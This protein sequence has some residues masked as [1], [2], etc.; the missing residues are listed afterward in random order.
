M[1]KKH[2][3]HQLTFKSTEKSLALKSSW[4]VRTLFLVMSFYNRI[5]LNH[6]FYA[7]CYQLTCTYIAMYLEFG[8][9]RNIAMVVGVVSRTAHSLP[10]SK[11]IHNQVTGIIFILHR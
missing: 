4:K 10:C 3:E 5:N 1:F 8:N 11:Y 9:T 6:D 2:L 7:S